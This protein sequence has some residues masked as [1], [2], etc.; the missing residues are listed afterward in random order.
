VARITFSYKFGRNE[1][2]PAR[3]RAT[4]VEEEKGRM[5]N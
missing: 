1:L 3:R 4:G 2:K 5:K